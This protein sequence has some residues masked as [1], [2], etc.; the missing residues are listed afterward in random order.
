MANGKN[1]PFGLIPTGHLI[2][3]VD[4]IKTNSNYLID[5][6]AVAGLQLLNLGDPVMLSPTLG[7]YVAANGYNGKDVLLTLYNPTITV[8]ANG[9]TPTT[10]LGTGNNKTIAGVFQGCTFIDPTGMVQF[11]TYFT[12]GMQKAGTAVRATIID[13]PY[14]I[15]KIQ[16]GTYMGATGGNAFLTQPTIFSLATGGGFTGGCV[17]G[18]NLELCI[19]SGAGGALNNINAAYAT[20]PVAGSNGLSAFYACPSIAATTAPAHD[21]TNEYVRTYANLKLIGFADDNGLNGAIPIGGGNP[22]YF[23]TPFLNVKVLINNHVNKA[24]TQTVILA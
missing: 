19:G 21:V 10:V 16:L 6:T 18:S 9:N 11:S 8:G 24:P 17:I 23:N 5:T 22:T 1:L 15:Y 20:N 13:D 12:A 3:G 7:D 14:V 4:D 2:S